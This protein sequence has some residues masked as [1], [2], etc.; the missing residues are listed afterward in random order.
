MKGVPLNIVQ[1]LLGHSTIIMTM[2]YAHVAP[3]TMRAAIELLSPARF[4]TA[5]FGQPAV[6]LWAAYQ[7]RRMETSESLLRKS[8]L[9]SS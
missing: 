8:G 5:D 3:S 9:I 2:R 1:A 6:N 7:Q 4:T